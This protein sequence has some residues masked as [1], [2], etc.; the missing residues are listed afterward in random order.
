MASFARIIHEGDLPTGAQAL[1]AVS[2]AFDKIAQGI[3]QDFNM[4]VRTWDD[5]PHFVVTGIDSAGKLRRTIYTSH[6]NYYFVNYG[7]SVR[8]AMMEKGF[9][10]KTTPGVIGAQ[11]GYGGMLFVNRNLKLPG[12]T[13]RR[14]DLAIVK[15]WQPR[16]AGIV[17]AELAKV[18]KGSS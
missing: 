16:V 12:I 7:T 10:P 18:A 6:R 3:Q 4:T 9:V 17:N 2:R 14:F 8:H 5:R 13:A 11:A 15:K 1:A